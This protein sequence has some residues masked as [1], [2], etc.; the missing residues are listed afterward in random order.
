MNAH[1]DPAESDPFKE[2]LSPL[3]TADKPSESEAEPP[4]A[5]EAEAVHLEPE[6][7]LPPES[8]EEEVQLAEEIVLEELPGAER[9]TELALAEPKSRRV[10]R[11]RFWRRPKKRDHQ[12]ETLRQGAAEMVDLMRSI[13][14]HLASESN[15]RKGIRET[16]TPLPVAVESLK[17]MSEAQASTGRMLGE[18][19]TTMQRAAEKDS[20]LIKSLNRIGNTMSNVDE[21]FGR[22]DRTLSGFDRSNRGAMATM[23]QLGERVEHSDRFME[24][25][26]ARLRDAEREF[27]DHV[28]RSARRGSLAMMAVCSI[29]LMSVVAVGFMF[30]ENR[31]LISAA[32]PVGPLVVQV[33]KE[34]GH[35][36]DMAIFEELN[37]VDDGIDEPD[38]EIVNTGPPTGVV[39]VVEGAPDDP[40]R[41][42]EDALL[43]ANPLPR[44][45]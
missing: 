9:E 8:E 27:T 17:S 7:I 34:Q 6:V 26:F 19:Q 22:M 11:W 28:S 43:S 30:K 5:V 23:K 25:T 10:P 37:A 42:G 18:L 39:P 29:L 38:R 20:Y 40:E 36:K 32:Q 24:E 33:P 15:E 3:P 1:Q 21:T 4:K 44:R 13:R 41:V 31:K 45:E 35:P 12:L 2:P 16:L 14:D